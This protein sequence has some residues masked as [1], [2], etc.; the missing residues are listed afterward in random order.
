MPCP[1]V[2]EADSGADPGWRCGL[3]RDFEVQRPPDEGGVADARPGVA[4]LRHMTTLAGL[5]DLPLRTLGPFAMGILQALAVE[6]HAP[7]VELVARS[8]KIALAQGRAA[9]GGAVVATGEVA[10][11]GAQ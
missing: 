7:F 2:V 11:G 3:A 6:G 10:D 8:A 4:A 5:A 1:L 9:H